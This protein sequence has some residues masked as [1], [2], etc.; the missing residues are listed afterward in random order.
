MSTISREFIREKTIELIKNNGYSNVTIND[1][2]AECSITK[3]TFYKYAGSKDELILDLYDTTISRLTSDP[4]KFIESDS[5]IEQL[6][7][8][9]SMLIKD[10]LAFGSELFSHMLISNLEENRH[11]FDMRDELTKIGILII[12]KAQKKGEIKN[13]NSPELLYS[14]LAHIFTGYEV[15]WCMNSGSTDI[16]D[17]FFESMNAVLCVCEEYKDLYKKHF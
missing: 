7:V 13:M 5:Y 16:I 10:T 15:I 4:Y 3:P 12:K 1:I 2:C 14:S 11:S 17:S 6:V 8:I 9:F